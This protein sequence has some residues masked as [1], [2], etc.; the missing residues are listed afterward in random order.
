[1][2][3]QYQNLIERLTF[4]EN[5]H[6]TLGETNILKNIDCGVIGVG[7]NWR[8]KEV[9]DT[10]KEV[11]SFFGFNVKDELS[12]NWQYTTNSKDE[13]QASYKKAGKD[14]NKLFGID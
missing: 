7:Q 12:W 8:G 10:Q 13:T 4:L 9:L 2:N 6:S 14:F 3:A 1:M 11:L 5:R